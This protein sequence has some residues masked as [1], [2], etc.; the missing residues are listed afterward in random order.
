MARKQRTGV[1]VSDKMEKTVVVRVERTV[2]H[3]LYKKVLSR[4]KKYQA[5]DETNVC[6]L[7]DQVRIEECRPISKHKQWRVVEI[8]DRHEVAEIQP[9]DI[10]APVIET[11]AP[12][13]PKAPAPEAAAPEAAAPEVA[14]PE[15]A[16]PEAA[17]PEAAAPEAAAPEAA[18]D[19]EAAS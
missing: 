13:T 7:G 14:A 6:V 17:A 15:A 2:T 8:L 16:T 3:P 12:A 1:V 11:A 10:Q 5:H 9:R 19:G 18:T 4:R